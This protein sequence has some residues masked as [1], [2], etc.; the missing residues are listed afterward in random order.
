MAP[1]S[2]IVVLALVHGE[3]GHAAVGIR[4]HPATS[5]ERRRDESLAPLEGVFGACR[6]DGYPVS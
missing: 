3:P 1:F 2:R 4:N 5:R 6:Y